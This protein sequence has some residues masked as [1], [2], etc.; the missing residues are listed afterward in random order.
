MVTLAVVVSMTYRCSGDVSR[1]NMVERMTGREGKGDWGGGG[2]GALESNTIL[3]GFIFHLLTFYF[4][5]L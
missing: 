5:V 1:G 2:G 3:W 4:L